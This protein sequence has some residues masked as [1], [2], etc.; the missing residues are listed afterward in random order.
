MQIDLP[1]ICELASGGGVVG[2]TARWLIGRFKELEAEAAKSH[3]EC[4][5]QNEALR[6]EIAKVRQSQLEAA[7]ADRALLVTTL[8]R[9]TAAVEKNSSV[10]ERFSTTLVDRTPP[11]GQKAHV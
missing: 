2:L 5:T 1:T 9:N 6:Q 10:L 8:E 4:L 3:A 7:I 11:Q